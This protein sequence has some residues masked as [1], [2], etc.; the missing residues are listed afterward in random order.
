MKFLTT[1]TAVC[2]ALVMTG[3]ASACNYGAAQLQPLLA[4]TPSYG[5]CGGGVAP[6]LAPAPGYAGGCGGGVGASFGTVYR[7][8]VGYAGY[9]SPAFAFSTG[10][11][12]NYGVARG[13][14]R[15][16]A[17]RQRTVIRAPGF[18]FRSVGY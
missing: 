8:P 18:R 1:L 11:G 9:A 16:F 4:P 17:P 13:F 10:Y 14:N 12:V 6:S 3:T 2:V 15:G 7:A 5:T